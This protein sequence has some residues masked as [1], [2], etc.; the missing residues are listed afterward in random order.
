MIR[1]VSVMICLITMAVFPVLMARAED[2]RKGAVGLDL[3]VELE[4]CQRWHAA[5]VGKV[6]PDVVCENDPCS[7]TVTQ[8]PEPDPIG[9]SRSKEWKV[10][11]I[12]PLWSLGE[13]SKSAEPKPERVVQKYSLSEE[14]I[15][16]VSGSE[17][18]FQF[19][20]LTSN[21][22]INGVVY[23]PD[24]VE[25]RLVGDPNSKLPLVLFWDQSRIEVKID[26][27]RVVPASPLVD[28]KV[29]TIH[30]DP[31]RGNLP[32]PVRIVAPWYGT[33]VHLGENHKSV[34]S[35]RAPA[36]VYDLLTGQGVR[37]TCVVVDGADTLGETR[38][39]RIV[40]IEN[41]DEEM[42]PKLDTR[43]SIRRIGTG[44]RRDYRTLNDSN[45][46]ELRLAPGFYEVTPEFSAEV[47][48][49]E[50]R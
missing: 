18:E 12:N 43:V 36:G 10:R 8:P 33:R 46:L 3:E 23:P 17:G 50:A 39:Q 19:G 13:D 15:E 44:W 26:D 20:R 28:V 37:E 38:I 34:V 16:L 7:L 11:D 22:M 6:T 48:V 25:V 49:L 24:A 47:L 41:V 2:D 29:S 27:E 5:Q 1:T 14:L 21:G 42:R 32:E 40:R 31:V 45:E 30:R 9:P 35:S 4:A